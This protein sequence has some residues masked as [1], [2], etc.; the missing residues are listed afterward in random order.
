MLISLDVDLFISI[1]N[2]SLILH[3][4]INIIKSQQKWCDYHVVSETNILGDHLMNMIS[5]SSFDWDN[6]LSVFPSLHYY[7]HWWTRKLKEIDL[8]KYLKALIIRSWLAYSLPT[9]IILLF[10]LFLLL[11]AAVNIS[12][13]LKYCTAYA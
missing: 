8:K 13:S 3:K 5:C 7:L 4:F 10:I 6:Y 11:G 1:W 9:S 2:L 12:R